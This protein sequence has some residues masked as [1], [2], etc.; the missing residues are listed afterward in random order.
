MKR[1]AITLAVAAAGMLVVAAA[2]IASGVYD[3]A[4]TEQHT[5]PVYALIEATMRQSI[6][7]HARDIDAPAL[8]DAARVASGR[9]SYARNCVRCHGAPGVA[10]ESFALGMTP[11]PANLAY[12]AREWPPE[13]LFWTLKRGLKMTG[14][15]AWAFR[16]S[17]DEMWNIVAYLRVMPTE[18]PQAYR[19][20]TSRAERETDQAVVRPAFQRAG[21]PDP[22]RGIVALR[23]YGC[24][25]CHRIPGVV[26]AD[27]SVGPPLAHLARR[28][29]IGGAVPNDEQGLMR[30]LQ[31]PQKL[32]PGSAM[33]DL[34]VTE[35]DA[36]D[37]AA[38]LATLQ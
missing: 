17:D 16:L 31:S 15:P 35:R 10:P 18:S 23:Q 24:A 4:A 19:A 13:Q 2:F 8:D 37:M 30:W 6:R 28:A 12:A 36:R 29:F 27:T 26:G 11:S 7:F 3:I 1:V 34:G 32:H 33:P 25:T 14:M 20:A 9:S 38:Y 21:V 5:R 22:G